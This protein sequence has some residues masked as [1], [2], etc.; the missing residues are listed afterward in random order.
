M[1]W[2]VTSRLVLA[3]TV[4]ALLMVSGGVIRARQAARDASLEAVEASLLGLRESARTGLEGWLERE[5]ST[6]AMLANRR[7]VVDAA[8]RLAQVNPTQDALEASP[9][10]YD[11]FFAIKR[12]MLPTM[13]SYRIVA[14]RMTPED[15][16]LVRDWIDGL[17]PG[18][19]ILPADWNAGEGADHKEWA[20]GIGPGCT[21]ET[22]DPDVF[23]GQ[24]IPPVRIREV[25]ESLNYDDKIRC[26]MESICDEDFSAAMTCLTDT[27]QDALVPIG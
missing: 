8:R 27:V 23:T 19:D 5:R 4:I 26:C 25:C 14:D 20:F 3:A 17:Y 7:V 1:S 10:H 18:G 13:V 6:A 24:A 11:P 21:G 2:K 15:S 9:T 16:A 22:A 12:T